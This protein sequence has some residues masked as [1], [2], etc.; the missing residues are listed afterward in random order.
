MNYAST[1][2]SALTA[3]GFHLTVENCIKRYRNGCCGLGKC[4][5][6]YELRDMAEQVI[7]ELEA[8]AEMLLAPP[9]VINNEQ[10]HCAE[11]VFI[12]FQKTKNP[13]HLCQFI[14]ANSKSDYVQFQA[15]SLL[16]QATIREWKLMD[17]PNIEQLRSGLLNFVLTNLSLQNYVREQLLLVVA[18]MVKRSSVEEGSEIVADFLTEVSRL[19]S[20][21]DAAMQTIGCSILTALLNE[22]SSSTRASDVGLTWEAHLMAKKK[23]E[24]TDLKRLFQ[25]CLQGLSELNKVVPPIVQDTAK[26]FKKF[27]I[28][29]EQVLTWNFQ[30]A[31]LL[32][33]KLVGMFE[34]QQSPALRPNG[35]WHDVFLDPNVIGLFFKLHW[36]VRENPDLCHHTLQCFHQLASLNG[37][38]M[39][40]KEDRCSYLRWFIENLLQ[41]LTSGPLKDYEAI[42][43]SNIIS[44][45]H[46]FF[47]AA[48]ISTLP[49]EILQAY[50]VKLTELTCHFAERAS[51]E[52]DVQEDK[53][54]ME[55]FEHVTEAWST[56][57]QDS[58]YF[59][60]EIV[61]Q[62]SIQIFNHYLKTHLSPPDGTRG[63][64][65][66]GTVVEIDE[67]EEDDRVKYRDQLSAIGVFG[68]LIT[69]HSIPILVRL[70]ED[71]I[72]RL[73]GQL[74]RIHQQAGAAND[75]SILNCL[76][77]DLH[78]LVMIT[79][80]LLTSI[81]EGETSLI[82]IEI[83]RFCVLQTDNVNVQT[84]LQVLA[85]PTHRASDIPGAEQ[86][87]DPVVRLIAAVFRLCEVEKRAM[88]ANL[89]HLLSP[90]VALT[91]VW[92][93]GRFS[94]CYLLPNETY[95][96]EMSLI[97]TQ[98]FGKDTEAGLWTL[99]FVIGK[100]ESNFSLW[101]S[102]SKLVTETAH[103]LTTVLNNTERG[104]K[105]IQCASLMNLVKK[106]SSGAY[107]NLPTAAKRSI[108]KSLVIVGT[109]N[110]LTDV[111]EK[112]WAELLK[113]LQD[114]FNNVMCSP[115]FPQA[116]QTKQV[117]AEV[118]DLIECLTGVVDGCTLSNLTD[119]LPV[120][121]PL[122]E[123]LVKLVDLYHNYNEVVVMIFQVF[124]V[125]AKR[126]LCFLNQAGAKVL[127]ECCINMI[128]VYA[129][130]NAGKLSR[131]ASAE[132]EQYQDIL[133]LMQLLTDLLF[134][135]FIDF[136]AAGSDETESTV[137]AADVSL[138][139]LSIIMP[140]MSADLL[141]F[142]SLCLQYFKL[143]ISVCEV[144]PAKIC[145]IPTDLLKSL[146][147]S[148]EFGLTSYT[149]D[150]SALCLD[151]LSILALHIHRTN[152]Q[153]SPIHAAL[154]PFLKLVF[155]M[156][157]HQP[158]DADLTQSASGTLY[159]LVCCYQ[160]KY[161]DLVQEL[162]NSQS[163]PVTA[164]RLLTSFNSLSA[165]M[166]LSLDRHSRIKFRDD[167]EK[168]IT[169][170][171]GYLCVK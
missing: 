110:K 45:L 145:Q 42:G 85:S 2:V 5:S 138:Y 108:L 49:A 4:E 155:D 24:R 116:Y 161:K 160:T 165:N 60:A 13:F 75:T 144:Q 112:Y 31:M 127:Y 76:N 20:S 32:P 163:D 23:F 111:K 34:S 119:L 69:D 81:S 140:M 73:H 99:D 37:C 55:A 8:S 27:L 146:L 28:I 106:Q 10:R 57:L 26:L 135:D 59:P 12:N 67:I 150:V 18:I 61:R 89:T 16:K 120:L 90:E 117:Q 1:H 87:T 7:K 80:H 15:A 149:S 50:L 30:F 169:E 102:E 91:L 98:A 62:S 171:R 3:D 72:T 159:A 131:E 152:L 114:R 170:V 44:R 93:L 33:R 107:H 105:A 36:Q 126:I 97:L 52:E 35:E 122:F 79:G 40:K 148:I 77:E 154:E 65:S 21:G 83:I 103:I 94:V 17:K 96:N 129:K 84:T 101:G 115:T 168:F 86:T 41:L 66:N 141:N 123:N 78:W 43:I 142:P 56:I 9:T 153:G 164:Q 46:V 19:I 130:H 166:T 137:S 104:D 143:V 64:Q 58:Q 74:Q 121:N 100:L 6:C 109:A 167:F 51:Q 139:G 53:V 133:L 29:A 63:M 136:P 25:Y 47:P 38:V 92:F 11:L 118:M 162:I 88:E 95:Y 68:R 151:F 128:R 134:K 157:L 82:P 113:P 48:Y 158:L 70:L 22:F 125:S 14:L 124:C 54:Y 71:R 132:E 156:L 39:N 147:S